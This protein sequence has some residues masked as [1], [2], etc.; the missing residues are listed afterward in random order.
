MS[1]LIIEDDRP[2]VELLRHWLGDRKIRIAETMAE[3][4]NLITD[5]APKFIVVDLT[6]P[7]SKAMQTLANIRKLRSDSHDAVVIVI[8]GTPDLKQ[9]AEAAGADVFLGKDDK[10]FFTKLTEAIV[11]PPRRPNVKVPEAVKDV[12]AAARDLVC[13]SRPCPPQ[14]QP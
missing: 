2:F 5:K 8:T 4:R 10:G 6:L 7:D 13:E 14:N 3:A 9:E 12:E 11:N 1:V